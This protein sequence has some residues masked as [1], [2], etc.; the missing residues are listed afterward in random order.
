MFFDFPILYFIQEH[1]VSPAFNSIMIFSSA[2]GEYGA[3]WLFISFILLFSRK[4]RVCG[5]LMICAMAFCF[6]TGEIVTKNLICRIRPCFQDLT[7]HMLVEKPNSY[8]FPS[9]H[10]SSSFAAAVVVFYFNKKLGFL[11]LLMAAVI[12]FSRMYLFVH[13]P[14]DVFAG[15]L[16]GIIGALLI[17]FIYRKF[18][19]PK[20]KGI[21]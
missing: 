19:D 7:V 20:L 10:S 21:V 13:F 1:I 15:I 4:T 12:A 11:T 5:I 3:V 18:F 8:S 17:I 16:W 2:I 9:G 14:S 6:I